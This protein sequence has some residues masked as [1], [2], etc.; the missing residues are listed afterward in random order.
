MLRYLFAV[1]LVSFSFT[2]AS[3]E[4]AAWF[5]NES[6]D[7]MTDKDESMAI[8]LESSCSYQCGSV[9][10]RAEGSIFISFG[11]FM[12][13]NEDIILEYRFDQE[14]AQTMHLST[15]TTGTAGFVP[16][17][18]VDRFA[19]S[20]MYFSEVVLRG[21]DY[22]GTPHT[23]KISLKNSKSTISK[24]S[25]FSAIPDYKEIKAKEKRDSRQLNIDSLSA[26]ED[27][28]EAYKA[29]AGEDEVYQI[30]KKDYERLKA[31]LEGN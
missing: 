9:G 4:Q 2:A 10:V 12:E 15:S 7:P 3:S 30:M 23:F 20:L 31:A 24:L 8:A 14:K 26:M 13:S 18:K 11:R 1:F 16:D 22:R 17:N 6:V 5:Y 27:S 28:M 21:Y 29:T 19:A 25:R